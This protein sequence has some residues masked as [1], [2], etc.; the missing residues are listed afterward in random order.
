M[1]R[2]ITCFKFHFFYSQGE[3][4]HLPK[5]FV[6]P[7]MTLCTLVT[8]WFCGNPSKKTLTLKFP[9][10]ADFE[11]NRMKNEHQKMK[12]LIDAVISGAK[13]IG[14]WDGQNGAWDVPR[15]I[16]LYESVRHL[17]K[18][19][20]KSTQICRNDQ[21]SLRTIYNSYILGIALTNLH[22]VRTRGSRR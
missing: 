12:G 17:F 15:A 1:F 22:Q 16:W 9:V 20:S 13:E 3:V 14:V 7:H 4:K 8:S 21:I 19:P 5:D 11:S 18:Y 2:Y 10:W 6:F